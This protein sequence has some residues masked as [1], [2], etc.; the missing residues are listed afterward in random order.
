MGADHLHA[1]SKPHLCF[2]GCVPGCPH[3]VGFE[4]DRVKSDDLPLLPCTS[5]LSEQQDI[6]VARGV[7][8]FDRAAEHPGLLH[9]VEL[10]LAPG[11]VDEAVDGHKASGG[12]PP[13]FHCL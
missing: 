9:Q 11:C 1:L 13:V 5:V 6:E 7:A 8:A 12:N 10:A 3:S 2:S 4:V